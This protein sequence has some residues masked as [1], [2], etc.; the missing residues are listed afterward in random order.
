LEQRLT[1]PCL[2]SNSD[3]HLGV[4]SPVL[5]ARGNFLSLNVLP[6]GARGCNCVHAAAAADRHLHAAEDLRMH[7]F[8]PLPPDS[9]SE[10][11][12]EACDAAGA[13][14]DAMMFGAD[15]GPPPSFAATGDWTKL[16]NPAMRCVLPSAAASCNH[17]LTRVSAQAVLRLHEADCAPGRRR[18]ASAF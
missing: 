18:A 10:P 9:R 1:R 14:I 7:E 3:L 6:F 13:L 5:N 2:Q 12:S 8:A 11:V 15:A 4:L 17:M 16:H